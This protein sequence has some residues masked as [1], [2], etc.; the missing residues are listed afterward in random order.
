[1]QNRDAHCFSFQIKKELRTWQWLLTRSILNL[2]FLSSLSLDSY[3]VSYLNDKT[4]H[5]WPEVYF[6]VRTKLNGNNTGRLVALDRVSA[7]ADGG[8][9][10]SSEFFS[11]ALFLLTLCQNLGVFGS[12]L[13][14]LLGTPALQGHAMPLA[15]QHDGCNET[16]NLR[17]LKIG[18][19]LRGHSQYQ[20]DK[21]NTKGLTTVLAFFP[22]LTGRGLL[23]TYWRTSSSLLKLKSFLKSSWKHFF[24][25]FMH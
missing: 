16:L 25:F 13:T 23:I 15:L 19:I 18:W 5:P 9:P 6:L 4:C 7:L 2:K 14:G 17:R 20:I 1:M 24:L 22:S 3:P 21:K 10:L 11:L 8:C 12:S